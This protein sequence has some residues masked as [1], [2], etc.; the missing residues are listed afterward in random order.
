MNEHF[1]VKG[2]LHI[3]HALKQIDISSQA[4]FCNSL[5]LGNSFNP[6]TSLILS[7]T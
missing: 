6:A 7:A 1:Y 4:R 2:K 5:N 3:Q